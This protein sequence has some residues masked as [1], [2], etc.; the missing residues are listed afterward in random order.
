MEIVRHWL[1]A[2]AR[3]EAAAPR[4]TLAPGIGSPSSGP[5]PSRI[6]V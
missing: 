2:V 1:L 5:A 6:L 3:A 4:F